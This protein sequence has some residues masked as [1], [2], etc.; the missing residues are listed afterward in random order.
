VHEPP[1]GEAVFKILSVVFYTYIR[2]G[3]LPKQDFSRPLLD[4]LKLKNVVLI[5]RGE[6]GGQPIAL[7][8]QKHHLNF[9]MLN[10]RVENK[11][12][13]LKDADIVISAVGKS[14]IVDARQLKPGVILLSVGT[15][16]EKKHFVSDYDEAAV[17]H[18]AS[19]YTPTPGGVGPVNVACLMQNLVAAAKMQKKRK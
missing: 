7:T 4:W 2:R 3:K 10:S 5:G 17:E 1:L 15:H 6:T 13:Y 12:D 18:V 19:Y 8:M 11:E 9:I 14:N 16:Y